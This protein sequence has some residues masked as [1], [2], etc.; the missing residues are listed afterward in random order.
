LEAQT[1][2]LE[3]Q[4]RKAQLAEEEA[5]ALLQ[6]LEEEELAFEATLR[7][8]EEEHKEAVQS[9]AADASN[10]DDDVQQAS[11]AMNQWRTQWEE[12][13]TEKNSIDAELLTLRSEF[14]KSSATYDREIEGLKE[15]LEKERLQRNQMQAALGKEEEDNSRNSAL[16]E[17]NRSQMSAMTKGKAEDAKKADQDAAFVA[18][19]KAAEDKDRER[20]E[21]AAT[22]ASKAASEASAIREAAGA[23][24]RD[25]AAQIAELAPQV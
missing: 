8:L 1:L 15:L 9:L 19:C 22:A 17:S 10:N 13:L 12:E 16:L 25:V 11:A 2:S 24:D 18:E 4:A 23:G 14:D 7:E 6:K 3:E 20:W 21:A 5:E